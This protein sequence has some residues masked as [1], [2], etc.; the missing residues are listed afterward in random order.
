MNEKPPSDYL[1]IRNGQ[2]EKEA[3]ENEAMISELLFEINS[4]NIMLSTQQVE[5]D[6]RGLN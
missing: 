3:I 1:L 5:L 4:L 2:L 6:K